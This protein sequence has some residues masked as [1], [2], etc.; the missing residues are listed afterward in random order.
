MRTF[1]LT[2]SDPIDFERVRYESR[3][4]LTLN[5]FDWMN[6]FDRLHSA[7]HSL[8]FLRVYK[9]K[10]IIWSSQYTTTGCNLWI[11]VTETPYIDEN[12]M[13][14]AKNQHLLLIFW[15]WLAFLFSYFHQRL[16]ILSMPGLYR[17][18]WLNR[19]SFFRFH[20]IRPC[21]FFRFLSVP[22]PLLSSLHLFGS[23]NLFARCEC[24]LL[25][26]V[27]VLYVSVLFLNWFFYPWTF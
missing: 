17:Y 27:G 9:N 12:C 14:H 2:I 22:C 13:Q 18:F 8:S 23:L 21:F 10:K 1:S 15:S 19:S 3:M 20:L 26:G 6:L 25:S 4:W 5:H 16:F 11:G 7:F 24:G